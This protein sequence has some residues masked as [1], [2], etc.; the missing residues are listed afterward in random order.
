M[1]S[2]F[3][4]RLIKYLVETI[5]TKLDR[6]YL[7]ALSSTQYEDPSDSDSAEDLEVL[8]EEVESLYAEILPVAQMSVDQ[9]HLE[10]T[11]GTLSETNGK[12]L[13]RSAAAVT[14][15]S[16]DFGEFPGTPS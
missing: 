13:R 7:E 10:P 11:L 8:R 16:I 15:V 3:D 4:V 14:Y 2:H 1:S 9:Q 12:S 5:R 6:V